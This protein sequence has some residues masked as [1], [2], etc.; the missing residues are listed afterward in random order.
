MSDDAST[1]PDAQ[2][3]DAAPEAP[4]HPDAL[5]EDA[6]VERAM[7][8]RLIL[9][10]FADDS[11]AFQRLGQL[12][13][14]SATRETLDEAAQLDPPLSYIYDREFAKR[15]HRKAGGFSGGGVSVPV[16]LNQI[17]EFFPKEASQILE[18][19]ALTRY[20]LT[21]LVTDAEILRN[22]EP[23][24]GL[25]KAI[26]QFKHLMKGDVLDAAR[27]IVDQ[28]VRQIA[29]RLMRDVR[30]ALHG[31]KSARGDQ[32]PIRAFRNVD[33]SR[34]I[35]RNLKN[36]NTDRDALV[37]SRL[38]FRHRQRSRRTWDII[39][40]VDQS[41]SMT[42]SLIHSAIMAAIFASLPSV[43]VHLVL[44]D[45]RVY[46]VTDMADDPMEVLMSCQLGGGTMLLPALQY[47]AGLVRHPERTI[48]TVLSDWYLFGEEA[49]CLALAH[50]L[51]EAGVTAIGLN[52]LDS[53]SNPIFN[54][55]FA[56][57]LAGCGWSVA[58][59]TPK[60]LAEHIGKL[61]A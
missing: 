16:W 45:H 53:D 42:D 12:A 50:E 55:A 22:S 52:A 2:P 35:R 41:G 18:Q 59:M 47:C 43:Q 27:G 4:A 8:W 49:S 44:W 34:T 54:E 39:V 7:R 20:G 3:D 25:L 58:T 32:P 15:S 57:Q 51:R 30:P 10:Q 33:W 60:Q 38:D 6:R 19:D 56:R 36:Y 23:T 61:I 17:R 37:I 13:P 40:A 11:L 46:D 5:S 31:A 21:E 9:G 48:L 28:V 24:E 14:D 1:Q 26:L 29:E